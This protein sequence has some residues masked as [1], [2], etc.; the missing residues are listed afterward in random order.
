[1]KNNFRFVAEPIKVNLSGGRTIFAVAFDE[2]REP[3]TPESRILDEVIPYVNDKYSELVKSYRDNKFKSLNIFFDLFLEN[4]SEYI[5]ISGKFHEIIAQDLNLKPE[6]VEKE[7]EETSWF[8]ELIH[9]VIEG[10]KKKK[11]EDPIKY[12]EAVR[13][14]VELMG[15]EKT[16]DLF[17]K[18]GVKIGRSTIRGL[19]RIGGEIPEIKELIHK[20]K[21]RLTLAWEIP[22][23]DRDE[24]IRLAKKLS[25]LNY[26]K[27]KEY[28]KSMK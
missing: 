13:Q 28:L 5:I 4:I 20:G 16:L 6:K 15:I 25:S 14:L 26:I 11:K 21:L 2:K 8:K 22:P 10:F 9:Y 3:Y 12:A 17:E 24:R 23:I 27:G 1:M 18:K 7:L 19:A